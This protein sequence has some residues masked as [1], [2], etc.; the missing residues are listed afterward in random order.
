MSAACRSAA[1]VKLDF[2]YISPGN[3]PDCLEYFLIYPKRSPESSLVHLNDAL[4]HNSAL[5]SLQ[6]TFAADPVDAFNFQLLNES[7]AGLQ[8]LTLSSSFDLAVIVEVVF[9]TGPWPSFTA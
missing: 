8:S 3:E 4:S 1:D 9:L 7:C 6:L 5:A 2:G